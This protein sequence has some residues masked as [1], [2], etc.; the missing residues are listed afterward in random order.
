[1]QTIHNTRPQIFITYSFII[2][3]LVSGCKKFVEVDPPVV[4]VT[5]ENV[6][7]TKETAVATVTGLYTYL[8]NTFTPFTGKMG[9]SM[10]GGLL[11]DELTLNSSVTD[12]KLNAYFRNNLLVSNGADGWEPCYT[13]LFWTNSVIEGLQEEKALQSSVKSELI[14][15]AKFLRAFVNFHLTNT[16]GA[17]PIVL[18]TDYKVN[19]TLSRSNI[20]DVYAQC[21]KDLTEAKSLLSENYL[22][23]NLLPY[24]SAAR[25][26][27]VN[28]WAA[29]ALLSR[30]YL[31]NKQYSEAENEASLVISASQTFSLAPLK[32]VFLATSTEAIWQLQPTAAGW[33]TEDAR[34]FVI[35]GSPNNSRP[36]RLSTYLLSSFEPGD[37]RISNWTKDTTI[38]A[39]KYTYPFKYKIATQ[40][41]PVDEYLT[42]LRLGEIYLVRSEA[43]AQQDKIALANSDL[44]T[45]R[46]RSGLASKSYTDKGSLLDAIFQERRVELFTEFGHR[47]FDLKR[48]DKANAVMSTITP[49]KGGTWTTSDQ[50][51]P[52]PLNDILR[53]PNITQNPGY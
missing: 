44:N 2:V 29:S 40:N 4:S 15:E 38:G 25:R 11:S 26:V 24:S 20:S 23:L 22:D 16:Y 21:I 45:I 51:L 10:L 13:F 9:I 46:N 43:R 52:L 39:V 31:Y 30:I 8:S 27:R 28:K 53:N 1:M 19:S 42:V 7:K 32:D 49:L 6:F 47:W 37:Q 17:I 50:L 5:K 3:F 33:N 35:N 48:A 18:T 14:G 34:V 12:T 36:I 41:K